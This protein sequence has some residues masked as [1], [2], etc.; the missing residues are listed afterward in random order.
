MNLLR[1]DNSTLD[2]NQWT[3][4]SNLV[5]N[6]DEKKLLSIAEQFMNE[7]NV[8]QPLTTIDPTL[9]KEFFMKAYETSERYLRSNHD[10]CTLSSNERSDFLRNAADNVTCLGAVLSWS[11]SQIYNY[12][13]FIQ[14]FQNNYGDSPLTMIQS[15]LKFY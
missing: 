4:L 12:K 3:L 15:V 9:P 13:P 7:T 2:S 5:Y 11:W 10:L 6:Y 1:S 14:V 8:I